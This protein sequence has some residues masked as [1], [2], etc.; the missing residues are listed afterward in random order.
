[1][2]SKNLAIK[3]LVR[4]IPA[5]PN[6]KIEKHI[7]RNGLFFSFP[8]NISRSIVELKP[9]ATILKIIN[10]PTVETCMLL[11]RIVKL[12]LLDLQMRF[13]K[14]LILPEQPHYKQ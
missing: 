1:M 3:P 9:S 2:K 11:N 4:G 10:N 12:L 7:P 13:Q 6:R 14:K 5:S 8:F